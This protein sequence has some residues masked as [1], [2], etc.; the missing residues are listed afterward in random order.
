MIRVKKIENQQELD[1]AFEIRRE[2]FIVGQDCPEEEEFDDFDEEA[3]HFIAY[4]KGEPAGTC[5][6]RTT[7]KGVKLERFAVLEK[8]RG[9]GIGKRLVQ[10]V[11][12]YLD[13]EGLA[14][15]TLIYLHSQVAAMG[16]Y[17]RFG[18]E[19]VGEMFDEVGI[20]HY[21]MQKKVQG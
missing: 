7:S 6:F 12:G 17:T 10:T 8:F 5:R 11:L 21:E 18:F 3:T 2:V 16:L 1:E 14:E 9:E 20:D 13:K 15:G 4:V 19:K